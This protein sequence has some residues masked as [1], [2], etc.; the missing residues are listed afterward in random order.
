MTTSILADKNTR[1]KRAHWI[2]RTHYRM[3][4]ASFA[5]CFAF[6]GGHIAGKDYPFLAW[7][8]LA[9]QFLI[10]PHLMYWRAQRA[11]DSLQAELNNLTFDSLLLGAWA[12]FLQFPVW[13]V[14]TLF[15]SSSLNQT[16]NRGIKGTLL[17]LLAFSGGALAG[18]LVFGFKLTPDTDWH[19]TLLGLIGLSLYLLATGNL[20]YASNRKL[21]DTREQLRLGEQALQ[22]A[23]DA[24]V[25]QLEEINT[26]QAQLKEQANRDPLTGL[27]NRRYLD[28][29]LEREL[30]RCKREGQPLS[31]LLLDIDHFKQINDTYGHQAGDEVLKNLAD[32]LSH[33]ARAA[34]VACRFGGEEFL[35]L[36]PNMPPAIALE[37][38]EQWRAAFAENTMAF[39]EFRMQSTLSIGIACYPGHGTSPEELVRCADQALYRAKSEGRNRVLMHD[40]KTPV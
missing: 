8:L 38:A 35:M 19:I 18:G 11:S 37:R 32:M 3:R 13:I 23:N 20:A 14:F 29:T 31:L 17:A 26:L 40:S 12:A 9:L 22:A 30:A 34:D 15:I 39:G 5:M 16:I 36:L 21:R 10:Y 2:V 25:Q 33:Q 4:A 1:A 24:L 28:S 27:Y 7:G 6:I